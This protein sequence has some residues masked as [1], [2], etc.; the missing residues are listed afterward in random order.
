[1]CYKPFK[2]N[3]VIII[4]L[5]QDEEF[6]RS[7]KLNF[8]VAQGF[9]RN[10]I[11]LSLLKPQKSNSSFNSSPFRKRLRPFFFW[12]KLLKAKENPQA[13]KETCFFFQ[14]IVGKLYLSIPLKK[15]FLKV[16]RQS[17]IRNSGYLSNGKMFSNRTLSFAKSFQVFLG[18]ADISKIYAK[19]KV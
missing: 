14:E 5:K 8:N 6:S 16:E 7:L 9:K 15:K 18:F 10:T 3:P 13:R 2:T 4:S 12:K 1:M 17:K 11:I 19:A